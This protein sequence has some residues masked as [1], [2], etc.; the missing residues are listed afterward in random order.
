MYRCARIA[1]WWR[2]TV[3]VQVQAFHNHISLLGLR[4]EYQELTET[5]RVAERASRHRSEV[6]ALDSKARRQ[7]LKEQ[8]RA[9]TKAQPISSRSRKLGAESGRIDCVAKDLQVY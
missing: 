4:A 9:A 6:A 5:A 2:L 1:T 3:S 8:I 7:T